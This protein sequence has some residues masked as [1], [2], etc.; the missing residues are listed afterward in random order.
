MRAP[1]DLFKR[2]QQGNFVWLEAATDLQSAR[3]RLKELS[4]RMPGEYLAFDQTTAQIVETLNSD[5]GRPAWA[6]DISASG[7]FLAG[8]VDV[9]DSVQDWKAFTPPKAP[10]GAPNFLFVLYDDTGLALGLPLPIGTGPAWR[11]G[12]LSQKRRNSLRI[13]RRGQ[14]ESREAAGV[15]HHRLRIARTE[16]RADSPSDFGRPS[17]GCPTENPTVATAGYIEEDSCAWKQT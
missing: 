1:F 7:A 16:L 8:D 14:R 9:R 5:Y 10:A 13:E 6:T 12:S 3:M 15:D 2:D 4:I 17:M 11:R